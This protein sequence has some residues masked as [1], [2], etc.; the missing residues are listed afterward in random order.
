MRSKLLK[1][2]RKYSIEEVRY[3][4]SKFYGISYERIDYVIRDK[5]GREVTRYKTY[6]GMYKSCG[7]Y[8]H[9]VIWRKFKLEIAIYA[10]IL[11]VGCNY[12]IEDVQKFSLSELK[13]L[14]YKELGKSKKQKI[15]KENIVSSKKVWYI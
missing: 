7:E 12:C 5:K 11:K 14:I 9:Q 15:N 3:G 2:I 6:D 8:I 10:I 13:D 4:N 1:K